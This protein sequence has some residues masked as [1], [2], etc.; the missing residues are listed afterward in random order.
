M[1]YLVDEMYK[2]RD[3]TITIIFGKE[4]P[5]EMFDKRFTD[6]Q[7]AENIKRHVYNMGKEK[8]SLQFTV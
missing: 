8:I 5:Y 1:L 3:K 7:W 6:A 4:I 2:Q